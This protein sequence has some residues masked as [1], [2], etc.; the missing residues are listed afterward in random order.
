MADTSSTAFERLHRS[1][2]RWIWQQGWTELR[3]AQEAA[4]APILD[5]AH[6]VIVAATT[7]S[8]KTEAAFLPI[9]SV[10]ASDPS[11]N[12]LALYISPLKA[13]IN[14]QFGR[15]GSFFQHLDLPA[16]H[17]HGDVSATKKKQFVKDPRGV[18]LITPESLEGIF[19]R[20]GLYVHNIFR[21]LRYIVV[22]ELHSFIG[23]ERGCQLQSL[24][25]RIEIACERRIPRIGL[26]ATLGDMQLAAEF[27]RPSRAKGVSVLVSKGSGQALQIKVGGF[28]SLG[29]DDAREESEENDAID[30]TKQSIGED[31]FRSLRGTT[32]LVFANSR[33]NVEM[34]ADLLRL[35]CEQEHLQNEFWP[36]HGSLSKELREY[37]EAALKDESRP[38]TAVCT[39]TLELGID[40]GEVKS[41]AQIGPPYSVSSLRQRLGR[42]GRRGEPAILRVYIEEPHVS[43]LSHPFDSLHSSLVQTIAIIRLLLEKWCEPPNSGGLHLSTLTHQVLA[44]IAQ[45][46]GIKPLLCWRHL[47]R[48][49]PFQ[50][51]DGEMFKQVLQAMAA[52]ELIM[53]SAD[54]TLLPGSL[55][56]KIIT[57]YS[58]LTVFWTPEEYQL[59]SGSNL[60]GTLPIDRPLKVNSLLIFGGRRWKI[61]QIEEDRKTIHLLPASGGK[62]P[63]FNGLGGKL[64]DRIRR[65][66]LNVYNDSL[67]PTFLDQTAQK[68]LQEG[69]RAFRTHHFDTQQ[70]LT[71]GDSTIFL[72]WV[73]DRIVDTIFTQLEQL[74]F[75]VDNE[76]I[77]LVVH[78][79]SAE[80]LR[81]RIKEIVEGGPADAVA[82]AEGVCNLQNEKYH[83]YLSKELLAVDYGSSQLD[84]KGA[85]ECLRASVQ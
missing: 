32:N 24:M 42:A 8:G 4:V 2:Q 27:L 46:G 30:I 3:D 25:Q 67:S 6:D 33:R 60:L 85:W 44:Q 47:C 55:G 39:S 61:V 26:S 51:I 49:G 31:I 68:L 34:F 29:S 40:V 37:A 52:K 53:Q 38:A 45:Y 35:R 36:H 64:H 58:F 15:L 23:S 77:G 9:G 79:V 41:V 69:R 48:D 83:A 12:G 10:L 71:W 11:K 19:V 50:D 65:E 84:T 70:F 1:V 80:L 75:R 74:G 43:E 14:D 72:P 57:H 62:V 18:L 66:M 76:G 73:G 21:Y 81:K 16:Y 56:E 22:D 5:G 7:A 13:L 82:L 54:G 20:D 63:K 78:D 28:E 59:I 17:W